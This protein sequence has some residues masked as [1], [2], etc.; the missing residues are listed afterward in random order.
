M[1]I[2]REKKKWLAI[3]AAW[4]LVMVTLTMVAPT[5]KEVTTP[6]KNAG[7]PDEA[8]SIEAKQMIKTYFPSSDG[9]PLFIVM[10]HGA[11]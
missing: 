8:L 5:A 4:L 7:L 2:L 3:I 10:H 9:T 1:K 6:A 11:V